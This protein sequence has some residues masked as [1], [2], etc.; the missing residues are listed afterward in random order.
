MFIGRE[1]ELEIL[2]RM[3]QR[4]RFDMVVLYGRRRVGK[5]ALIDE[6]VKDKDVLYFTALEQS[7]KL[8]LRDFTQTVVKFFSL[9]TD[10]PIFAS[11]R[12]AL[13]FVAD[14]AAERSHP[15]VFVFDEFPYAAAVDSSLPSAMQIAIDHGFKDTSALLIL[16]GSNESFMEGKV[17]G[18]KSPLYGRRTAQIK[19]LPFDYLDAA[20]FLPESDPE[21]SMDYYATFGGTPYYLAQ[22]E[23]EPGSYERNVVDL[24]F[25]SY[26]PLRE[27]PMMLLREELR[28]PSIYY[29]V[30]QA[31][32]GGHS[33]PKDIAEHAGVGPDG[34][35]AYLRTL[36]GLGLAVRKVP[37]GEDPAK[38]RKGMWVVDD[39]FFAYWFR[40]VGPN[41]GLI[42]SG[43]G[44]IAA[45]SITFG[46]AYATY[47]G[48][49][50]ED[51]CMQW[52]QRVNGTER[53]PML[54]T[55]FGKWWGNNPTKHE[56]TDIDLVAGNPESKTILLGECKWRNHYDETAAVEALLAREGLIKGYQT[57]HFM[58]FSKHPVSEATRSKYDSRVTF[59]SVEDLYA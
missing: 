2:N 30:L 40:F 27:E 3:W 41:T 51:I 43:R 56:Q 31:M 29:S 19:L 10:T 45:R 20:R 48:Q 17:L 57:T 9:P 54:A 37:F 6:F 11:W 22:L 49:R 1:R 58:F 52:L 16:S 36:E 8:N 12:S 59:L 39:P 5:T 35:G 24:C 18:P 14:K 53:L 28:E 42:Q 33:T 46:P 50:F 34:I 4:T 21:E 44:E 32:S 25:D 26:G 13:S 23:T 38:S 7:N 15:F 47:V 55:K